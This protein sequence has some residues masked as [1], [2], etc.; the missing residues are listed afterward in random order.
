MEPTN[1]GWGTRAR[2]YREGRRRGKK[3]HLRLVNKLNGFVCD[4]IGHVFIF[5]PNRFATTH[6]IDST[7]SVN[8]GAV[9]AMAGMHGQKVGAIR[10]DGFLTNLLFEADFDGVV[11]IKAYHAV[12]FY[13]NTRHTVS[14]G[15]D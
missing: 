12:I 1:L 9:M 13:V 14:G 6:V 8:N 11:G 4:V 5:P 7:D 10:S 3:D 15:G 2:E